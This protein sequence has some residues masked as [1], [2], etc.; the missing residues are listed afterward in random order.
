M[1]GIPRD[2]P[3]ARTAD[4]DLRVLQHWEE[5]TAW[6]LAHT[7]RWP[8]SSR[9]TLGQRVQ[10]HALDLVEQ[11]VV[12]RY[13]P[14]HRRRILIE[15][16]LTLERMRFLFRLARDTSVMPKSGFESAMR[17]VDDA[18]RMIHGWRQAIG[19]RATVGSGGSGGSDTP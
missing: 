11:L 19:D 1:S 6:L 5:F 14:A 13:D 2:R 15:I 16:N 4:N 17:G 7:G 10:N 8:K 18:G 9:F 12:A 3:P